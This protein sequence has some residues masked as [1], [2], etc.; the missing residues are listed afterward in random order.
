MGIG[1]TPSLDQDIQFKIADLVRT[2]F[3]KNL[4]D[5]QAIV[6]RE[7]TNILQKCIEHGL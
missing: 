5:D 2:M 1:G 7:V 6:V 3:D 4:I